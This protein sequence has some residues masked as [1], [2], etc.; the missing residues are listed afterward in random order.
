MYNRYLCPEY[1]FSTVERWL[2]VP[3]DGVVARELRRRAGRGA[4]PHWPTLRRLTP[5]E[6][7]AYQ[8]FALRLAR[9]WQVSRVD[10]DIYLW[11]ANR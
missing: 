10:I 7:A 6:H 8:E 1:H 2:E 4:L 5:Q 11:P 9:D 3:L